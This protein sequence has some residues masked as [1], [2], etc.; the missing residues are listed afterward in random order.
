VTAALLLLLPIA[1]DLFFFVLARHFDY[2]RSGATQPKTSLAASTQ[3]E[4]A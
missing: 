3:A 2:R 4:Y 1:F